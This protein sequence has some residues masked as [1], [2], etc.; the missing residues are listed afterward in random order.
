MHYEELISKHAPGWPYPVNYLAE[1]EIA[2]D[3]LVLGGGIAGCWA[4]IAAAKKGAKV[5]LVEKGATWTSGAGGSGVDHWHC[6]VTNPVSKLT[7]EEYTQINMEHFG[8]WRNA[9]MQYITCRDSYDCLLELEK[10]GVKIRDSNDDFKGAEFRDEASKLLFAYDY[11]AKYCIR[12]WGARAKVNLYEEC[13]RLGV[14]IIDHVMVTMLLNKGGQTGARIVGAAGIDV[15]T[16]RF[17]VFKGKATILSMAKPSA[18]NWV[19]STELRGPNIDGH[20]PTQTGDGFAMAWRAGAKITGAEDSMSAGGG[21]YGYP[22]YGAGNAGNTWYACSIIDST[23]KEIPWLDRDGKMLKTV[24]ERY[25]PAPGQKLFLT[26]G[27]LKPSYKYVPPKLMTV[28]SGGAVPPSAKDEK[29]KFDAVLPLW[30]DLSS[31]PEMERK[32]IW[33]M[34]I[35]QEGRTLIPI[36][37]TYTQAG[38]DPDKDMLQVYAGGWFGVG[39]PLWRSPS[40][41]GLVIDWDLLTSLE[42]LYAAGQQV[43]AAGDHAYAAATGQYAGRKAAV[44]ALGVQNVEVNRRQ[45][46][47]EKARVSAPLMRQSGMDWKEFNAGVCRVMQDYCG[48]IKNEDLLRLGL[49]WYNELEAGEVASACARNPHELLRLLEVFNIM[50]VNR[51]ILEA[52]RARKASNSFLGFKRADYPQVDPQEWQ[53]WIT[54]RREEDKV[55]LGKL[56]LDYYGDVEKNYQEHNEK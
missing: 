18:R 19:F 24:S 31:M 16:G 55:V 36:Y 39:S 20:P 8:G 29:D 13:R 26:H 14:K 43:F 30:A 38:F 42:G 22:Q 52:C 10:M 44:Y 2:A 34:M 40:K 11:S 33:G 54:L 21:P 1:T 27:G 5:I 28:E 6:A 12:I 25:H 46:E 17:Y 53:R 56:P 51:V 23:G 4:A 37:R 47:M 45:I 15:H 41:I 35:S 48:E 50:T 32:V 49:R 3:V 9:I 7:P